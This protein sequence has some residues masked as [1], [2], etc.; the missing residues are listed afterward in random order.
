[1][2]VT[3]NK[4]LRYRQEVEIFQLLAADLLNVRV[5]MTFHLMCI[6]ILNYFWFGLDC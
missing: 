2:N 6:F 3:R 5:S 4:L 1:M